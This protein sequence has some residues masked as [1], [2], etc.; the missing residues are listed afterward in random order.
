[1]SPHT[2]G[3][4]HSAPENWPFEDA[5]NTTVFTTKRIAAGETEVTGVSH[6]EDGDWQ[7]L[8][9]GPTEDEDAIIACLQCMYE[10]APHIGEVANLP[11]NQMAWLDEDGT[12]QFYECPPDPDDE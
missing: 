9:G 8:D 3:H 6:D 11:L 12:W 2:D 4:H 7:F 5:P 1:M 10:R